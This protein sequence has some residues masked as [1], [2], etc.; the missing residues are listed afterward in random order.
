MLESAK[1]YT[2]IVVYNS[3]A[4][5]LLHDSTVLTDG[6]ALSAGGAASGVTVK[7]DG[8]TFRRAAGTP[9]GAWSPIDSARV[10]NVVHST[11]PNTFCNEGTTTTDG[12][13]GSP[14]VA[15][16]YASASTFGT[17]T[18]VGPIDCQD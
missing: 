6:S 11:A 18:H 12:A 15:G 16:S 3:G 13:F 2:A 17:L 8:N 10:D 14:L 7:L 1:A 4:T 9:G 5:L